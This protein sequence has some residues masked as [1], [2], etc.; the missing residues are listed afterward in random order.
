M[1]A[2]APTPDLGLPKLRAAPALN[3]GV[4]APTPSISRDRMREAASLTASAV[5]PPSRDV[6]RDLGWPGY[7]LRVSV[8]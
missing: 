6:Q 8:K 5:A 4:V 7:R 1:N 2:V 3:T